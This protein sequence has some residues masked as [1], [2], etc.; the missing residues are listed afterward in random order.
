VIIAAVKGVLCVG[1]PLPGAQNG[2]LP[3][4]TWGQLLKIS[5]PLRRTIH[6]QVSFEQVTWCFSVPYILQCSL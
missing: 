5:T 6:K 2:C 1:N 3:Q 4:C